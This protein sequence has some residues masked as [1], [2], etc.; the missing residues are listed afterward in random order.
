MTPFPFNRFFGATLQQKQKQQLAAAAAG[1]T[2]APETVIGII[3]N[4]FIIIV[5][6]ADAAAVVGSCLPLFVLL[7]P[8]LAL[9]VW[10]RRGSCTAHP[11]LRHS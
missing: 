5:P 1:N 6:D 10:L 8:E 11:W 3:M 7:S 4:A 2:R 9:T